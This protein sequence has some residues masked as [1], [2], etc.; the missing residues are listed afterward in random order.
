MK[1][2]HLGIA[3]GAILLL[4]LMHVLTYV[5]YGRNAMMGT[6]VR[7]CP[8]NRF[9]GG[10]KEYEFIC[11][12]QDTWVAL[13]ENMQ[14]ALRSKLRKHYRI[15]Y[16]G[17]AQVPDSKQYSGS[18]SGF[19]G[20]RILDWEIQSRHPFYFKARYYEWH[21]WHTPRNVEVRSYI[22]ILFTWVNYSSGITYKVF[23]IILGTVVN[24]LIAGLWLKK[25][26]EISLTGWY[27]SLISLSVFFS[28]GLAVGYILI[29]PELFGPDAGL[30]M[31]GISAV[32]Y[33]LALLGFVSVF[34]SLSQKRQ[35]ASFQKLFLIGLVAD[36]V[37]LVIVILGSVMICKT[38]L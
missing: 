24:C 9:S 1:S 32:A 7:F 17:E 4:I 8:N 21:E 30:R 38:I 37:L 36:S 6:V 33:S 2:L 16:V 15:V 29:P 26:Y 19:Y 28:I 12:S 14:N 5:L 11:V 34:W 23:L 20:G 25:F 3:G 10:G 31:F 35:P 13:P 22:W 18:I 27:L